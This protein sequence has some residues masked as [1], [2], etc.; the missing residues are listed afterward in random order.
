MASRRVNT[1]AELRSEIL[2][3]ICR[4]RTV[5]R[6]LARISKIASDCAD[7]S[8]SES[9][10]TRRAVRVIPEPWWYERH[11]CRTRH[12]I[13][14]HVTSIDGV[15]RLEVRFASIQAEY[16][17]LGDRLAARPKLPLEPLE[18]STWEAWEIRRDAPRPE[19]LEHLRFQ[20]R[21]LDNG[22]IELETWRRESRTAAL[23]DECF[24]LLRA[25]PRRDGLERDAAV[26]ENRARL[27]ARYPMLDPSVRERAAGQ[28]RG[29]ASRTV[30]AALTRK[31]PARTRTIVK[32][33]RRRARRF[34]GSPI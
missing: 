14:V 15:P 28:Q 10:H 25:L 19:V 29:E 34:P 1:P 17:A 16:S 8:T 20:L 6:L 32:R 11:L 7:W 23:F 13:D 22:R 9:R 2:D 26:R 27:D 4:K 5:R 3:A 12:G 21:E 33:G 31:S 18:A 24:A 30:V